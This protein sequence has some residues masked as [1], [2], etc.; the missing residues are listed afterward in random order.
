[1]GYSIDSTQGYVT[2][3]GSRG[4]DGGVRLTKDSA[5]ALTDAEGTTLYSGTARCDASYLFYC[6]ADLAADSDYTLTSGGPLPPPRPAAP[7]QA[8]AAWTAGSRDRPRRRVQPDRPRLPWRAMP[9]A[10]RQP[11]G[12]AAPRR[13][14]PQETPPAPR[15]KDLQETTPSPRLKQQPVKFLSSE[16]ERSD[17][18]RGGSERSVV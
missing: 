2:Y 8:L 16:A 13:K 6:G 10:H 4:G 3:G 15:R 18:L 1:M 17:P 11:T 14:S 7:A 9:P 12:R 5:F